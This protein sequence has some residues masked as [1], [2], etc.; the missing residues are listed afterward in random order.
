MKMYNKSGDE[1]LVSR[2]QAEAMAKAGYTKE[3]PKTSKKAEPKKAEPKAEPKADAGKG[4][5][6]AKSGTK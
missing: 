4:K 3:A 5:A 2:D 1:V 6:K